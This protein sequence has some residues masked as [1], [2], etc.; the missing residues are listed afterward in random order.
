MGDVVKGKLTDGVATAR[1]VPLIQSVVYPNVL[2]IVVLAEPSEP[3][4]Q[5]LSQ[6]GTCR[7]RG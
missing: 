4:S 6:E 5:V 2:G 3:F 1:G 7:L